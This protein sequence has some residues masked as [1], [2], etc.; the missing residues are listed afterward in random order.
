MRLRTWLL[1]SLLLCL[2][3]G[4][5]GWYLATR[6]RPAAAAEEASLQ[7]EGM[8]YPAPGHAGTIAPTVRQP[9]KAVLVSEGERVQKGQPLIQLDD[10]E[11]RI[12]VKA[13]KADRDAQQEAVAQL[14]AKPFQEKV[15]Q[16][17]DKLEKARVTTENARK[18]VAMLRPLARDGVIATKRYRDAQ[19]DYE[20]A[21]ADE[22]AA[23]DRL[24]EVRNQPIHREIREEEAKL[25]SAIADW[26]KSRSDL[27]DCTIRAPIAGVISGLRARPGMIAR[28]GTASWGEILDLS[29]I[30]VRCLLPS[31]NVGQVA[32]G[33]EA[34]VHDEA[35]VDAG[36]GKVVAVGVAANRH[37]KQHEIPVI[38]RLK[39]PRERLRCYVPVKVRFRK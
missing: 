34:D 29:V 10:D 17:R 8:T 32:V 28:P 37:G 12:D 21:Q 13:K 11:A 38:L 3:V 14:K 7:A 20:K 30:D 15:D 16:A 18:R 27:E 31:K 9:I 2:P 6:A 23:R 24:E 1:L 25:R 5:G 33:Q 22:Q 26:E 4:S 39:N 19:A 36:R 35:D